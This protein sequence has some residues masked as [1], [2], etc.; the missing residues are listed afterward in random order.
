[1]GSPRDASHLPVP[2]EAGDMYAEILLPTDGSDAAAAAIPH[3]V[4]LASAYG[5]RLHALYALDVAELPPGVE[6]DAL[7][8]AFEGRGERAVEAVAQAAAAEGATTVESVVRGPAV[9][10]ILEYVEE[11][12]V[13]LVVMGTHGWSR[14]DR[15]VLGSVARD[16]LQRSPVP[17]VVVREDEPETG[18][19][20]GEER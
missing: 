11:H 20:E 5:A 10:A 13:D 6:D 7:H 8:E 18:E 3:A 17:V 15:L 4:D 14:L 2:T 16:V 19:R 1:M 9:A 12:D